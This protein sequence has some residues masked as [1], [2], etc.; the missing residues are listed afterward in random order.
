MAHK[1]NMKVIEV[2]D[3]KENLT[4]VFAK[5]DNKLYQELVCP[6]SIDEF[7]Q[8][9]Y[10]NVN[11]NDLFFTNLINEIKEALYKSNKV[12]IWGTKVVAANIIAAIP[13]I[14]KIV[15]M[16]SKNSGEC[17]IIIPVDSYET[18]KGYKLPN[19]SQPT[20]TPN[21][22]KSSHY[23]TVIVT[24]EFINEV[25]KTMDKYSITYDNIIPAVK[26]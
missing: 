5:K 15:G 26:I 25:K 1:Y 3:D 4:I 6:Y 23:D 14:E 7:K 2:I 19:I 16:N 24:T 10:N 11:S 9:V 8:R 20:V 13:D 17:C 22:I 12:L 18:R 21:D